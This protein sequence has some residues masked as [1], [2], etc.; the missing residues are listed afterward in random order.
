MGLF[1]EIYD[2]ADPSYP[3][4]GCHE[5]RGTGKRGVKFNGI[6]LHEN[7]SSSDNA[8]SR[9]SGSTGRS[10]L[11]TS[12]LTEKGFWVIHRENRSQ[13]QGEKTLYEIDIIRTKED[14]EKL[15]NSNFDWLMQDHV[16]SV[17]SFLG[18]SMAEDLDAEPDEN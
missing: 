17:S 9:Y 8:S 14:L 13:W 3:P 10:K 1:K 11:I 7:E 5:L 16:Y 4:R 2:A 15:L 6:K 18:F 12:Y